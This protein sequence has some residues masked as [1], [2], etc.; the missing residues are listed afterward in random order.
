MACAKRLRRAAP[1]GPQVTRCPPTDRPDWEAIACRQIVARQTQTTVGTCQRS[2]EGGERKAGR[3]AASRLQGRDHQRAW[4][5]REGGVQGGRD[6]AMT[7]EC[8]E[9]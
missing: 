5:V 4:G 8:R 9:C 7:T 6:A 3:G 1:S 2:F